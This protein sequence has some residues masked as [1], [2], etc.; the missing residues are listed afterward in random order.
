MREHIVHRF[1]AYR[2]KAWEHRKDPDSPHLIRHRGLRQARAGL[3][4]LKRANDGNYWALMRVLLLAYGRTGKRRHQLTLPLLDGVERTAVAG[5]KPP[6]AA[7]VNRGNWEAYAPPLSPQMQ[8]LLK[9]QVA[10]P[11]PKLTRPLLRKIRPQIEELNSW[12]RPMP[13]SRVKNQVKEW[14]AKLLDKVHPPLPLQEWNR[15]RDLATGKA[16]EPPV[17]RRHPIPRQSQSPLEMVLQY[18]KPRG[19]FESRDKHRIT[20]RFMQRLW[21]QVFAQCPL[22]QWDAG[23]QKWNVTWGR[24]LLHPVDIPTDG[25]VLSSEGKT[26]PSARADEESHLNKTES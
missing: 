26:Q 19:V 21:A 8:A 16:K 13:R 5:Q 15:L 23:R 4:Q 10:N 11:P 22:M 17:P 2:F 20:G 14:Y 6:G 25:E 3:G 18:G 7:E 24:E 12:L 1:G 9:S